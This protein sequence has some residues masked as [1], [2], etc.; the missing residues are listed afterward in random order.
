MQQWHSR[1]GPSDAMR[2]SHRI[3]LSA[4]MRSLF[5][6]IRL[7]ARFFLQDS[8]PSETFEEMRWRFETRAFS[9]SWGNW[10]NVQYSEQTE[11]VP[12]QTEGGLVLLASQPQEEHKGEEKDEPKEPTEEPKEPTEETKEPKEEPKEKEQASSFQA[13]FDGVFAV[14]DTPYDPF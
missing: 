5:F 3:T 14:D 7:R 13:F 2:R 9:P 11:S 12:E 4:L 1:P 8:K 10:R 6:F